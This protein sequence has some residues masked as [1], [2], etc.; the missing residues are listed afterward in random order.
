MTFVQTKLHRV[1]QFAIFYEFSWKP[2]RIGS[3]SLRIFGSGKPRILLANVRF[4][5]NQLSSVHSSPK[6]IPC[7][8]MYSKYRAADRSRDLPA[9]SQSARKLENFSSF[10]AALLQFRA[11]R[12]KQF[13]IF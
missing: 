1:K 9:D 4:C 12:V 2:E 7:V 6:P 13:G 11:H 10:D 3:S 5:K 8:Y